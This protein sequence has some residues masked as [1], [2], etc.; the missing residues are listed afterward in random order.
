[1][2]SPEPTPFD[3][4]TD[5][6]AEAESDLDAMASG[7]NPIC[8]M[9][10]VASI[11]EFIAVQNR[12]TAIEAEEKLLEAKKRELSDHVIEL[13]IEEEMDSPPGVDG[14]TAYLNPVVYVEKKVNPDTGEAFTGDDIRDALVKS[15]LG[16]MIRSNYNG[17]QLRSLLREY[18]ENQT[19]VPKPLAKVVTLA[20]RRELA[21]TPMAERKRSAAPRSSA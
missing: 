6:T 15:G 3:N 16:S 13:M 14:M 17:N 20:K 7:D 1:M 9:G 18:D 8:D 12:L 10:M 19:S 5:L 2:A 4:L 21:I 11:R